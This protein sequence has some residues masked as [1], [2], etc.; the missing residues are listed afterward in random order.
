[1]HPLCFA[2][3]GPREGIELPGARRESWAPSL[4]LLPRP[5]Q[6]RIFLGSSKEVSARSWSSARSLGFSQELIFVKR[7]GKGEAV[8]KKQYLGSEFTAG[9]QEL[10]TISLACPADM[11][12]SCGG[13]T[14]KPPPPWLACPALPI[15]Q[16]M[17]SRLPVQEERSR[18]ALA[19]KGWV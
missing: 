5:S 19:A 17:E 10:D 4:L 14:W 1:M 13:H 2:E 16:K 8:I 6:T 15:A 18:D 7:V 9:S 11:K 12:G 3:L